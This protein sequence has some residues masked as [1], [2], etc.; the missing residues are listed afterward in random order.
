MEE[1]T[2]DLP[3]IGPTVN[4]YDIENYEQKTKV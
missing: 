1:L 4:V 2:A 3:I